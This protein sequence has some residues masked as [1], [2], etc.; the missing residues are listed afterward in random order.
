M[1]YVVLWDAMNS[2]TITG[3]SSPSSTGPRES[4]L[5]PHVGGLCGPDGDAHPLQ[6]VFSA[7]H[8]LQCGFCTSGFLVTAAGALEADPGFV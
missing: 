3:S 4:T 7:E 8:G 6:R 2:A 1:P 5:P